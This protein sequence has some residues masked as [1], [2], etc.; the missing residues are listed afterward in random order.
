MAWE[1][2][3]SIDWAREMRGIVSIANAVAPLAAIRSTPSWFVS[4]ARKPISTEPPSFGRLLRRR[5]RDLD[6]RVGLPGI[7]GGRA[8]LLEEGVGQARAG[9]RAGLE[10]DL[11][12][13][14]RELAHDLGNERDAALAGGRLG[15]D[16]DPQGSGTVSER[17]ATGATSAPVR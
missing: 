2:S 5:R 12:A 14:R 13:R 11:V 1:D 17:Q 4:G 15:G 3:A 10:H 9:A 16:A 6:D 8:G 7:A